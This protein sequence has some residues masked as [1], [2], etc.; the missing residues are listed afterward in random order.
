MTIGLG[1]SKRLTFAPDKNCLNSNQ[2]YFWTDSM[3]S[4]FG[5]ELRAIHC[6]NK[7]KIYVKDRC[8]GY[9]SVFRVDDP[10][11]EE[12]ELLVRI[13]TEIFTFI[14]I[15]NINV[16]FHNSVILFVNIAGKK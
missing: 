4:G 7:F 11:Y 10:Q 1:Y 16:L 12:K 13:K 3:P 8:L 9:A 14:S 6:D 5:F 15:I 2:N